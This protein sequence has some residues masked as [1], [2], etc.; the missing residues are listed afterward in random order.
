MKK[1]N[2]LNL[3]PNFTPGTSVY[4]VTKKG[5]ILEGY[6]IVSTLMELVDLDRSPLDGSKNQG[7]TIEEDL[8]KPNWC[9][10]KKNLIAACLTKEKAQELVTKIKTKPML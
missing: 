5:D 4:V 10:G 9:E 7:F 8:L 3:N 1:F 2:T 6:R